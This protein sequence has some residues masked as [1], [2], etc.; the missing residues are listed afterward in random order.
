MH[1]HRTPSPPL[2]YCSSP[3][4][5]ALHPSHPP[6]P[7]HL[8]LTLA[9]LAHGPTS[10]TSPTPPTPPTPQ[11]D[12]CLHGL[13]KAEALR[14]ELGMESDATID[15]VIEHAIETLAIDT[16]LGVRRSVS[17]LDACLKALG[18]EV[19]AA[20]A[21]SGRGG[22]AAL[23]RRPGASQSAH[24][25]AAPPASGSAAAASAAAHRAAEPVAPP[26]EARSGRGAAAASER[27]DSAPPPP[28]PAL[29]PKPPQPPVHVALRFQPAVA[30]LAL[31]GPFGK[32]A[33]AS[34]HSA[35][36]TPA[37]P[38]AAPLHLCTPA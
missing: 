14:D 20:T 8:I 26:G 28:P 25:A 24:A 11:A 7:A 6:H 30:A 33:C 10:P 13:R 5:S 37:A 27:P 19:P 12:A 9:H 32:Q 21:R 1:A 35:R 23:P 16:P 29:P 3:M 4:R 2:S 38:A 15:Q 18:V 36:S 22:L 17:N 34:A 31:P